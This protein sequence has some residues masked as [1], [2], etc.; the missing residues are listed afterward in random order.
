[1]A[2]FMPSLAFAQSGINT[3]LLGNYST[4][5]IQA[6]NGIIV[7]VLLAIAFIVF[8]YGIFNYFILGA[9]EEEKRKDGRKF[10]L[11]GIIGFVVIFSVWGLVTI[12]KDVFRLETVSNPA[13]PTFTSGTASGGGGSTGNCTSP[14]YW[15]PDLGTCVSG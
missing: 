4:G 7:P 10:T 9:A 6:I 5:I 14:Y 11:W 15:E 3:T 8:I 1:M 13:P 2:A 12:V